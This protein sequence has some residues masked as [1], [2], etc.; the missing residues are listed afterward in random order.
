M[1]YLEWPQRPPHVRNI[2]QKRN[3]ND[4]NSDYTQCNFLRIVDLQTPAHKMLCYARA[5]C[6]SCSAQHF[7]IARTGN[8]CGCHFRGCGISWKECECWKEF[9]VVDILKF[10]FPADAYAVDTCHCCASVGR[11]VAEAASIFSHFFLPNFLCNL[12]S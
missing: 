3:N 11:S 5:S 4:I 9:E 12:R 8:E 2:P 7:D 10:E 1:T 6:Y